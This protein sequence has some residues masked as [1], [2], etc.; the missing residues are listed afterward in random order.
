VFQEQQCHYGLTPT[1]HSVELAE[2][3]LKVDQPP[4]ALPG[5]YFL[6]AASSYFY[7]RHLQ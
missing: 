3:Y 1:P 5:G 7:L 4:G 2:T 6:L